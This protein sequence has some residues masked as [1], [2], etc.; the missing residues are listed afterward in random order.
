MTVTIPMRAVFRK[1]DQ[2]LLRPVF[3]VFLLG[4]VVRLF[5]W[6]YTAVINPDGIGYLHQAKALYY[7]QWKELYA[8]GPYWVSCYP[9]F[10]AW[11]Y[12]LFNDWIIA[13]RAVSCFFGS[14]ALVPLYLLARSFFDRQIS[15]LILLIFA[16]TPVF[17]FGSVDLIRDPP[18]WFFLCS[19]LFFYVKRMGKSSALYPFL[20]GLSFLMAASAR[21]DALLFL[22]LSGL[23]IAFTEKQ[24]P[25]KKCLF[26]LMP[27]LFAL[28]PLAYLACIWNCD[29]N[30]FLRTREIVFRID[31]PLAQYS[32]TKDFLS[33]L[34][35]Q[36]PSSSFSHFLV[37]ARNG[38]WLVGIGTLLS[39]SGE[40]F[41][42]P[43]FF[44]TLTGLAGVKRQIQRDRRMLYFVILS[45][46]SLGLLYSQVL[47]KWILVYRYL[48]IVIIPSFVFTGL[49][50]KRTIAFCR[51]R[52][53]IRK[54][55]LVTFGVL[56]ALAVALPKNLTPRETDKIVFKKIGQ[57]IADREGSNRAAGVCTSYQTPG[58]V[59]FYAN[60]RYAGLFCGK[61][62]DYGP[63]EMARGNQGLSRHLK[64]RGAKYLLWEENFWPKA[65]DL[66]ALSKDIPLKELGR[67]RQR[68]TGVMVL[69]ELV[70]PAP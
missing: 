41:F 64:N 66:E 11:F 61:Q 19:G 26:F 5:A 63:R 25:L 17:V 18:F 24:K 3:L 69:Y 2:S 27:F 55:T 57:F 20:S 4:L 12:S 43:F 23:G 36:A 38:I 42:Y 1:A 48:A 65:F 50:I 62:Y 59:S 51:K 8:C 52:W 9:F 29:F 10:I 34:I 13:A 14:A 33:E 32:R 31:N 49:G 35:R 16:L 68:L 67:W 56:L 28:I 54:S 15:L 7:G 58:W 60:Y 46:F 37:E 53:S 70:V 6:R 30:E 47:Y 22:L 45:F 39:R 44:L 21:V 40:A